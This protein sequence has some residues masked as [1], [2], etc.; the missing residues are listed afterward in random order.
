MVEIH[1]A[2]FTLRPVLKELANQKFVA[3]NS[4]LVLHWLTISELICSLFLH[5]CSS[6]YGDSHSHCNLS[7][8]PSKCHLLL[9][10][11]VGAAFHLPGEVHVSD[12][13]G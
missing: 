6:H 3:S 10:R 9:A 4:D 11:S 8:L 13:L 12:S 5:Q 2:M 7:S 1:L